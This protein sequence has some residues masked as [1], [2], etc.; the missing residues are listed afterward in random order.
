MEH[1]SA[2]T[3]AR[4][5]DESPT[6][7]ERTH[8]DAC[9]GCASELATL[10]EQTE[11]LGA[12]PELLPPR[13]DWH[14]LEARLRSEGLIEDPG[15]FRRLGLLDTPMWMKAAAAVLLFLGGAGTGAALTSPPAGTGAAVALAMDEPADVETAASA[16]RMAEQQYVDAVSRYRQLLAEGGGESYGADPM[17][18]FAALEHLVMVS[19]A[20]VRQAPGDPFLNGFLASAMAE[21]DAAARMVSTRQDN[22]F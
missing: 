9:A 21:R 3:L 5:V 1:L 14:V 12:L 11:A 20:A 10:R 19:Q 7:E 18:R 17:S 8:L 2:E 16:V 13:G 15:L 22:W 6:P 4:L